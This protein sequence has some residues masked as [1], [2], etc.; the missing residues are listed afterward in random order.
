MT[1]H[2]LLAAFLAAAAPAEI[3]VSSK[4]ID[5][6]A[7]SRMLYPN[8][9]RA[10]SNGVHILLFILSSAKVSK[11]LPLVGARCHSWM[12]PVQVMRQVP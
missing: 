2:A 10:S 4:S 12:R 1:M 6:Y 3:S 7:E 8:N 9:G 11:L 5:S